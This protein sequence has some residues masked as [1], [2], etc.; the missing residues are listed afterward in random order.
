MKLDE[1]LETMRTNNSG[2]IG[3]ADAELLIRAVRQ[4]GRY[5]RAHIAVES[6]ILGFELHGEAV[7]ELRDALSDID[8]D[9]LELIGVTDAKD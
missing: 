1:M 5:Y 6:G 3:S 8:P 7:E 9:V 2:Q 4:L